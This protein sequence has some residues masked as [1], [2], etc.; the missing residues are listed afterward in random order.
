[1][2]LRRH[3]AGVKPTRALL[4]STPKRAPLP[5]RKKRSDTAAAIATRKSRARLK[6]DPTQL[7]ITRAAT[8]AARRLAAGHVAR[9]ARLTAVQ[10][11]V[12]PLE[13]PVIRRGYNELSKKQRV[14]FWRLGKSTTCW[15]K[16]RTISTRARRGMK[17]LLVFV[18]DRQNKI[19]AVTQHDV[20]VRS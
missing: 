10:P 11:S 7:A 19:T 6:K 18:R 16:G 15:E 8:Q 9:R 14:W 3:P 13:F 20:F 12:T 2:V 1:M 4:R 5:A 17:M